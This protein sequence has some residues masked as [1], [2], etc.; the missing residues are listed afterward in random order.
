MPCLLMPWRCRRIPNCVCERTCPAHVIVAAG[1]AVAQ[2]LKAHGIHAE[3]SA[4]YSIGELTAHGGRQFARR[5]TVWVW[6]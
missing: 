2:A 3:L 1:A 5:W 4:G 6:R